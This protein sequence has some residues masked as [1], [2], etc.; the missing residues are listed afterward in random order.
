MTT[1]EYRNHF[2]IKVALQII[3]HIST[4]IYRDLA[5]SIK[6]LVSNSF[7]S[8]A[9]D[10]WIRTGAPEFDTIEI[11]DNGRGMT[12]KIFE[13][14]FKNVG[15][16]QKTIHPELY[17]GNLGR[18]TIGKFGIGFLAAAHMSREIVIESFTDA[19]KPG[20]QARMD[21]DP[22]F[23]YVDKVSTTD[24][25]K[26]GEVDWSELPNSDSRVGTTIRLLHVKN[27]RFHAV[28]SRGGE[29]F[30]QWPKGAAQ[31]AAPGSE[32]LRLVNGVLDNQLQSI[33]RLSGREEILWDLGMICPVQY[34]D[35]GPI[36]KG[37]PGN[38]ASD[39]I[40]K[41]RQ[42]NASYGFNVWYDGVNVRKPIL[43]PSPP[44]PDQAAQDEIDP[45]A[46]EDPVVWPLSID[47]PA[48]EGRRVV[49]SGYMAYQPYRLLPAEM[50]GLLPR[51]RGV[52]VGPTYENTL[53][54]ELK[55]E[56]PA[57]RVQMSGELYVTEGLDEE[58]NLDRS[59][60][61][62]VSAEYQ[63]LSLELTKLLR[64][65]ITV[66]DQVQGRRRKRRERAKKEVSQSEALESL[67]DIL[68]M[69]GEDFEV[70]TLNSQALRASIAGPFD[71]E[72]RCAYPLTKPFVV[73]DHKAKRIKVPTKL[74]SPELVATCVLIDRVLGKGPSPAKSRKALSG[75]LDRVFP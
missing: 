37:L 59:G 58:L 36:R 68:Q 53:L 19:S 23:R 72:E 48:P 66:I 31:E 67:V 27:S 29:R 4:G 20:I 52:G 50:R 43:F 6:E 22:Y 57:Y 28:I 1:F 18:P 63:Y 60:F 65:F 14:A 2:S 51:V 46:P 41:S 12:A 74:E 40:E 61:L 21:L 71:F 35:E 9:T 39:V 17:E 24:E 16:S 10:V 38:K 8:Q 44:S 11:I 34:L 32:M 25:F 15:Q 30:V 70:K 26:Y 69:I 45:E 5:G 3:K 54:R 64:E 47:G 62:D 55:G 75:D 13:T 49:A 73:I 33:A 42:L 7:D 56:R